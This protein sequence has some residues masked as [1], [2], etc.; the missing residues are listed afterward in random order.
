MAM[1]DWN[2][3]TPTERAVIVFVRKGEQL[4]LIHKKRGLGAG[5]VNGPGGRL[6]L[7]ESWEEAGARETLEETGIVP[8]QLVPTAEL[9]FQF[10]NGYGLAVRV[11]LSNQGSGSL[12]SCDEADPFWLSEADL[13]W[14]S[15]W[16]D[17][18]LWL[19]P[20]L[21]GR[22]VTG[23]YLFDGERMKEAKMRIFDRPHD[24]IAD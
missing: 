11:F 17:D 3:W 16:A 1:M 5:K 19:R 6:E 20:I 8:G 15:M 24:P 12:V 21:A 22:W 13:P 18:S 23:R 7:G 2:G 4:L 14:A 10:T 9:W